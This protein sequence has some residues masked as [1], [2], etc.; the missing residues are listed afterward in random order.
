MLDM[1]F[2]NK[3][4]NFYNIKFYNYKYKE[5]I[6]LLNKQKSY[7][8]APAASALIQIQKNKFYH[9]SLVKSN[10][11]IFDSGFFC[12][13]LKLFLI[14]NPIK[15]SG[16]KFLKNFLNDNRNLNKKI[17]IVNSTN[18]NKIKNNN[19]L[20]KKKFKKI[21]NYTSPIYEKDN[22][23]DFKLLEYV[24]N[25][26]PNYII[27]NIAGVK[28]EVLANFII[29]NID[30]NCSIICTGAAIEFLTGS[31]PKI[32]DFID[33]YYMGWLVRILNNPAKNFARVF[34]SFFL[35]KFIF[36]KKLKN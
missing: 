4:L 15:Y 3:I 7:L 30:F 22:I 2:N 20:K 31:Q 9:N 36:Q 16:L 26:R 27:T 17:L 33:K 23:Y 24:K 35:L 21:Y 28:Q 14:F 5:I 18:L 34:K 19:L 1:H 32:N 8:V 11:A 13:L 6:Y 10:I 25:V 29:R 12:L